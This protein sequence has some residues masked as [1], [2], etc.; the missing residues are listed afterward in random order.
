MSP[1]GEKD[2]KIVRVEIEK[3]PRCLNCK[4]ECQ[5]KGKDKGPKIGDLVNVPKECSYRMQFQQTAERLAT[6]LS[7][8]VAAMNRAFAS[9]PAFNLGMLTQQEYKAIAEL[10][11]YYNQ[12]MQTIAAFGARLSEIT[13][14]L[15]LKPIFESYQYLQPQFE[16]ARN[17]AR[18]MLISTPLY[19]PSQEFKVLEKP[20]KISKRS[21]AMK[22]IERLRACQKGKDGWTE[23]QILCKEILAYL[24]VPPLLEPVEQE[25]TETGLH[26]RDLIM[27]VPYALT[28][29]WGYIRDK[30]DSSALVVECKNYSTP[31]EGNQIVISSKYLGRN[32][33]GR[34][35][36]VLSRSDP[37]ESA[38]KETRRL[39]NED[40]KMVLC[41]KDDH[42]IKMLQLKE[43]TKKPEIVIDHV[44]HAFLRSLE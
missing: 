29:F 23:F 21:P 35:G 37:A 20:I 7:Q 8:H 31:V 3:Q 42:L 1:S 30:F 14:S 39:W 32:R 19:F 18:L 41:L 9:A 2:E 12:Q 16:M 11:K 25:R 34:F 5:F 6:S 10:N 28:G 15:Q 17:A 13:Q 38:Y 43:I 33:L 24:F 22:L 40:E 4:L 36:I 27:D 44:I 26:V